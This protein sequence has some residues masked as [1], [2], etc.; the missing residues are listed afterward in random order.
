[1]ARNFTKFIEQIGE[2]QVSMRSPEHDGVLLVDCV[3]A[4]YP[5]RAVL[6]VD[7]SPQRI[8]VKRED[9]Q[10]I[11]VESHSTGFRFRTDILAFTDAV[12]QLE[13]GTI[14]DADHWPLTIDPALIASMRVA[15]RLAY[16]LCFHIQRDVDFSTLRPS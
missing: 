6:A 15:N 2:R 8:L 11:Q 7:I 5:D 16:L 4:R 12:P 3:R 1:M 13:L 9:G 14:P 10:G